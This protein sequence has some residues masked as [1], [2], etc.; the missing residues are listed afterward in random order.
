M[1][2]KIFL[3]FLCLLT[4]RITSHAWKEELFVEEADDFEWPRDRADMQPMK[5]ISDVRPPA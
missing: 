5:G 2:L 1:I 4:F 3:T